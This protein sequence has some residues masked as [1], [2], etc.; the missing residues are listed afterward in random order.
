MCLRTKQFSEALSVQKASKRIRNAV[1]KTTDDD[2]DEY[3]SG[4]NYQELALLDSKDTMCESQVKDNESEVQSS[5]ILLQ[6]L[7]CN[8]NSDNATK[9]INVDLSK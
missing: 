2:L 6:N 5:V 7:I 1:P 4:L 3:L 8:N 9:N